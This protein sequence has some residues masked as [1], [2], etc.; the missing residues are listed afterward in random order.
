VNEKSSSSEGIRFRISPKK[1]LLVVEAEV[2]GIG[3][4][5]FVLDTGASVSV[6]TPDTARSAGVEPTGESP[7]AVGAGGPVRARFARLKTLRVGPRSARNLEVAVMN[8]D[9]IEK[10]LG[11][12]VA[13]LI[14]YNFLRKYVV[15]IDYRA[16]R[17]HLERDAERRLRTG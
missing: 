9:R 11:I 3:P 2:N 6:I 12:R 8:L 5:R 13:G 4:F 15:I 1:P 14:G 16:G 10:P 17:L 7:T